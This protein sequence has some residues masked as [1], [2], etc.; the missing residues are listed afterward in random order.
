[1]AAVTAIHR[2]VQNQDVAELRALLNAGADIESPDE[3]GRTL[4]HHA[5][6]VEAMACGSRIGTFCTWI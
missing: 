2:A 1:M 5:V 4:L 3:D 6:E